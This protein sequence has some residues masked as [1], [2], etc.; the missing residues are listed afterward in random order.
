MST[1]RI[2]SRLGA[3]AESRSQIRSKA[4]RAKRGIAGARRTLGFEP[5]EDRRLLAT[6][7][8]ANVPEAANYSL[9]Y[10]KDIPITSPGWNSG[11]VPY[12][13]NNAGAITQPL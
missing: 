1:R 5:L 12:D 4:R 3:S 6:N 11:A 9:V 7:L 2:R 13:V 8:W 10:E